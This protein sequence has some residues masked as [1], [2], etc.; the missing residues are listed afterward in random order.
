MAKPPAVASSSKTLTPEDSAA[1]ATRSKT[2]TAK[3][4]NQVRETT[5][6]NVDDEELVDETPGTLNAAGIEESDALLAKTKS[7]RKSVLTKGAAEEELNEEDVWNVNSIQALQRWIKADPESILSMIQELRE[8]RDQGIRAAEQY[9][10]LYQIATRIEKDQI[11][12]EQSVKLLETSE[13][14]L[15]DD[16]YQLR[17]KVQKLKSHNRKLE[18]ELRTKQRKRRTPDDSSDPDEDPN[19][20]SDQGSRRRL[21]RETPL[22]SMGGGKERLSEKLK[23]PKPFSGES[24]TDYEVYEV[25]KTQVKNKLTLNN[26]RYKTTDSQKVYVMHLLEGKAASYIYPLQ[27]EYTTAKDVLYALDSIYADKNKE[28][29][30]QKKLE[31]LEQGSMRFA[32]FRPEFARLAALVDYGDSAKINLLLKKLA[33]SLRRQ[34][35]SVASPPRKLREVMDLLEQLDINLQDQYRD[36]GTSQNSKKK[37]TTG[38]GVSSTSNTTTTRTENKNRAK[39]SYSFGKRTRR[40]S[41]AKEQRLR[42]E[43]R[44]FICEEKGHLADVCPTKGKPKEKS[45]EDTKVSSIEKGKKTKRATESSD[46]SSDLKSESENE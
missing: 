7:R 44:C 24:T 32:E 16:V 25:W 5:Q 31:D 42:D 35:T 30:A 15:Q 41:A 20:D 37:P 27:D 2:A 45:K 3:G 17:E 9:S 34:W 26:D 6:G 18:E 1:N 38:T 43:G 22:S 8:D 10:R 39:P 46:T 12:A 19:D 33:P 14:A 36:L 40:H 29:T 4:K 13:E 28:H 21:R 11:A 23:D